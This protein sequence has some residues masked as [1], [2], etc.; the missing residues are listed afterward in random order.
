[1]SGAHRI[2]VSWRATNDHTLCPPIQAASS[3]Y[4]G[5]AHGDYERGEL[6]GL[7]VAATWM[8]RETSVRASGVSNSSAAPHRERRNKA[9]ITQD[10]RCSHEGSLSQSRCVYFWGKPAVVTNRRMRQQARAPT[11]RLQQATRSSLFDAAAAAI[12]PERYDS[13]S[14]KASNATQ[15]YFF[16]II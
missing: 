12:P 1:M 16:F 8:R 2:R 14:H 13:T 6:N 10:Q 9:L 3:S 7:N 11:S 4:T 5:Q 15:L